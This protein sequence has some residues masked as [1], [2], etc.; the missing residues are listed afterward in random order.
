LLLGWNG[1]SPAAMT[2]GRPVIDQVDK[3]VEMAF[4]HSEPYCDY[5]DVYRM[6]VNQRCRRAS[7]RGKRSPAQ[8]VR[9]DTGLRDL[10]IMVMRFGKRYEPT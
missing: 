9:S 2:A 1:R 8:R 5:L 3:L 6:T 10:A 7:V 4:Q